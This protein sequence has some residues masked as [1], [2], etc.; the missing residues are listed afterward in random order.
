MSEWKLTIIN[1]LVFLPSTKQPYLH[2]YKKYSIQLVAQQKHA[3][4]IRNLLISNN[5][6]TLTFMFKIIS[7]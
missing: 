7:I 3:K 4:L 1:S 6:S 5:Y 2:K